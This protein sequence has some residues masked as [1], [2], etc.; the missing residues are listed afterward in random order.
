MT[1]ILTLEM[2][3]V[4]HDT[5]FILFFLIQIKHRRWSRSDLL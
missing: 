2:A 1:F 4:T 3:R 5:C